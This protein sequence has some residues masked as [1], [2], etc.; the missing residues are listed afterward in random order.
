MG[1][2][3]NGNSMAKIV[4][5]R[6]KRRRKKQ[7]QQFLNEEIKK[8]G[9]SPEWCVMRGAAELIEGLLGVSAGWL[10]A[11]RALQLT[12]VEGGGGAAEAG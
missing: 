3:S 2:I 12:D 8:V 6:R 1:A 5:D 7:M 11:V 4:K 9:E 10:P